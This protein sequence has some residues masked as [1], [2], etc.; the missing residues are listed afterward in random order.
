MAYALCLRCVKC[1]RE[2]PLDGYSFRCFDCNEPLEV[3]YDYDS[4]R[5]FLDRR[6]FVGEGLWRYRVLLPV[7]GDIVSLGEGGS[8]LLGGF[9]IARVFGFRSLFLKDEGRNPTG[10]FKD[11]GSSVGVSKALEVKARFVGCASTGNMAASLS[12]YA[13]KAGLKCIIL[14]PHGTPMEKLLQVLYYDPMVFSVDLPY[15]ELYKMSFE[16]SSNYNVF[17]VHSDSPFRVEGQKTVAF[18]ICEQLN[19]RV[20]DFVVVPTSSGGN[21][22]AIWKGFMEFYILGL[23]DK[24]PRMVCVQSEGCAPIV[25]AFKSGGD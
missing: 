14:V 20:P 10:S 6:S 23:I 1:G 13:N 2:F 21:F 5:K 9:R 22:S 8:P 18:E 19:W 24:L 12:A 16:M 15:P 25:E 3:V 11:R 17:L 7:K 4:L